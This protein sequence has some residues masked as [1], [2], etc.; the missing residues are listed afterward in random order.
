[1]SRLVL[2]VLLVLVAAGCS[3]QPASPSPSTSEPMPYSG[4]PYIGLAQMLEER[5]VDIWF[6]TDL[7]AAWLEGPQA[8]DETVRRLERLAK[9]PGVVGFKIAD[10]IGYGDGL[11]SPARALRFLADADR[12]LA[13]AAPSAEL[14]VDAVVLELGCLT[15]KG[16]AQ[17]QCGE[18]ARNEHPA[19]TE[20]AITSYL[21]TGAIDRLD[22]STGLLEES[23]YQQWGLTVRQAQTEAWAHVADSSWPSLTRLQARKALAEE[24]GYSGSAE[25]AAADAATYVDIPRAAGARAVDIWTWRQGYDGETVTLLA[26]DLSPNPLWQRLRA[27]KRNGARLLTHMTPSAMPTAP[28]DL[29]RECDKVAEVFSAVFVAAGTG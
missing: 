22:L 4:D 28:R 24:G 11:G 27:Q 17:A 16:S 1:M 2:M 19:A 21:R 8:F 6:E 5:G 20:A 12:A 26:D 23:T 7:V 29:A 14:L 10:E 13:R 18:S 25:Q 3:T 9:V 15:W